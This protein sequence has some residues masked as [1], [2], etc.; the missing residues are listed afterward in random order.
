MGALDRLENYSARDMGLKQYKP[1]PNEN[2]FDVTKPQG[3]FLNKVHN[4]GYKLYNKVYTKNGV[5]LQEEEYNALSEEEKAKVDTEVVYTELHS[6]L[7]TPG[8]QE[9]NAIAGSGKALVNTTKV[10]TKTG[11][12]EIARLKVGEEVYA[13]DGKYYPITGVFPQG[14]KEVYEVE[15]DDGSIIPCC[16]EHLWGVFERHEL[17]N[18]CTVD[19]RE[20]DCIP[21]TR[22]LKRQNNS[23]DKYLREAVAVLCAM[24]KEGFDKDKT[25]M[26][27]LGYLKNAGMQHGNQFSYTLLKERLTSH[28][29]GAG[30]RCSRTGALKNLVANFDISTDEFPY[31]YLQCP[32]EFVVGCVQRL[33]EDLGIW[34]KVEENLGVRLYNSTIVPLSKREEKKARNVRRIVKIRETGE[35]AEMTCISVGSPNHLFLTEHNIVTHNT[36]ALIFKLMH[37]IVTGEVKVRKRVGEGVV[38]VVN[39]VW[40][41]TFL[42][43][44]AT[45][46]EHALIARQSEMGYMSTT[47][48]MAISTLDA[49]FKRCLNALGV[50]TNIGDPSL[51]DRLFRRA[52]DSCG[53]KRK[54]EELSFEDYNIISSVVTYA[55]GRLDSK[56]YNHPSALDYN[57]YPTTLDLLISVYAKLRRTEGVLDFDEIQELLYKYLYITP[58]DRVQD[59]VAAR[60]NYIY[61]DE[62]QDT[63]QMQYAILKFYARGK[64]YINT[65]EPELGDL[66]TDKQY[67]GVATKGKIVGIGDVSQCI[68]SFKGSDSDILANQFKKD[69]HPSINTLSY[70]YRCP[71]TILHPIV[72][73][74]HVNPDSALQTIN[75][76]Q[77]GGEFY[78]CV[79]NNYTQMVNQL[80]QDIEV[81]LREGLSVAVLCRTNYDG[82]IP[83]FILE[84]HGFSDFSISGLGM[85]LNSPLP[86]KI[87]G[88]T[89]L[90]TERS[91]PMVAQALK[92]FADKREYFKVDQLVK[93]LKM[94]NLSLWQVPEID[95]KHSCPSLYDLVV[96]VKR[97]TFASG[98][99]D[100]KAEVNALSLLYKNLQSGAFAGKSTYSESARAYI[101][102]LLYLLDTKEFQSVYDF[103]LEL[104]T[105][106]ER[107]VSKIKK[108]K[109]KIRIATVHEFKGKECDSVY[110]WNDID[111]VFPSSKTNLN[112]ESEV[113]EERRIHYIACTRAKKREHIYTIK[114]KEG[115]FFKEMD[116]RKITPQKV[117]ASLQKKVQTTPTVDYSVE[118]TI[119]HYE[120]EDS[121]GVIATLKVSKTGVTIK[122]ENELVHT[123]FLDIKDL[124]SSEKGKNEIVSFK[125]HTG[126]SFKI[127]IAPQGKEVL[128]QTY[129][130]F[131]FGADS[132][133]W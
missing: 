118:Y 40:V 117:K 35:Y 114:G 131:N 18:V 77:E 23:S 8:N 5:E 132:V 50:K 96:S 12:K 56:R 64:L 55:R 41:C 78:A 27:A 87:I 85:T 104:D 60:Y 15:F 126:T 61:I 45:E 110:V 75:A 86:K 38:E 37:D 4:L 51:L 69:F 99:R 93:T 3:N 9:I 73:S 74:I 125:L 24:T 44:G 33:A 39:K 89:S 66:H 127:L 91:T 81:D 84:S 130:A 43:T 20:G 133:L 111:G 6:V 83:A 7:T 58:N 29:Y 25:T 95:L 109:A 52:V 79:F 49:E 22:P 32:N 46:L 68:Y 65:K 53:I 106:G 34:C 102:A 90:F 10:R 98:K 67:T 94:N 1:E 128:F 13:E 63:S 59:F 21:L 119:K 28:I 103:L 115:K 100:R 112:V 97:L 122:V 113:A 57:L 76:F 120:G 14:S 92:M 31:Y 123:S 26:L 47:S 101:D 71:N 129:R 11:Y 70:N 107:L 17:I 124:V 105:I 16:S 80:K 30:N 36:T 72:S 116:I 62:F 108:S 19:L 88:V 54:G 42:K 82:T 48:Q 121:E 2:V